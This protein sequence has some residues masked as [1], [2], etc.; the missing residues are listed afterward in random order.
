MRTS[1]PFVYTLCTLILGD[2]IA[3]P[4]LWY[5]G[6]E[7]KFNQARNLASYDFTVGGH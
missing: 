1:D 4:I 5:A 2:G 3:F 7:V 6:G